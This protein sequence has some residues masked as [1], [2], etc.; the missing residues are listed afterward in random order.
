MTPTEFFAPLDVG[1]D[2]D[3][4]KTNPGRTGYWKAVDR[5]V[6]VPKMFK[7]KG[8]DHLRI[9]IKDYD[10]STF[11]ERTSRTLL[12]EIA[13]VAIET[14][15]A[16]M[17][18]IVAF[19][20]E[21]FKLAPG[22]ATIE[23]VASW[24]SVLAYQFKGLSLDSIAFNLIIETT[25]VIPDAQLN[26]LYDRCY[27]VIQALAPGRICIVCPNRISNPERWPDL[28][29]PGPYC[30]VE[31]HQFAAGPSRTE[32]ARLWTT[33]TETEKV[34]IIAKLDKMAAYAKATGIPVWFGAVMAGDYN[35]DD[36]SDL[37]CS[38]SVAEQAYFAD[39]IMIES[40]NRGIP[41][42]WNSDTKMFDLE[43]C[44]WIESQAPIVSAMLSP[45]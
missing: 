14:A 31:C 22:P 3:F 18:A 4:C 33:G 10:L 5:G 8:F 28:I 42:A 41:V 38:Y 32:K 40:R 2:V 43:T 19:Q 13:G 12:Q 20:G 25:G 6:S 21:R 9:R 7:D 23:E 1:V 27:K 34:P 37:T 17:K 45:F 16:G 30:A 15:R 11:N 44:T 36:G 39:W 29:V 26:S 35:S 24:W